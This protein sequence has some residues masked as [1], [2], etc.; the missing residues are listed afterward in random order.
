MMVELGGTMDAPPDA[1]SLLQHLVGQTILTLTGRPNTI[2]RVGDKSVT[3]A[4]SRSPLGQPVL[5]VEIQ[6][7][8][9]RLFRH[10]EIEVSVPSVGYRSAFVGAVLATLPGVA[11]ET[12][13]R[14]ARLE[15][16]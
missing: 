16:P 11:T 2:L 15:R 5:I 6:E 14:R 3:V 8:I 10:G 12:N 9:D 1:R 13:P 7:A 4:T